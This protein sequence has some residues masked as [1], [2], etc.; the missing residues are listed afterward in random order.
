MAAVVSAAAVVAVFAVAAR[1]FTAAVLEAAVLR[2]MAEVFGAAASRSAA[3][4][5]VRRTSTVAAAIATAGC[6]MAAIATPTTGIIAST[7]ISTG[8]S[9]TRRPITTIIR[10]VA[11]SSGPIGARERSAVTG[12]TALTTGGMA[13]S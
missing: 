3:A 5:I 11:G 6:A 8:G 9:I 2:S 7:G 13:G 12:T 10:G 1:P 4:V